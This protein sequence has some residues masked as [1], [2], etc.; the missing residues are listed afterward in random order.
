MTDEP[1]IPSIAELE[2]QNGI[3]P[4]RYCGLTPQDMSRVIVA[5]HSGSRRPGERV[6]YDPIASR[7]T[8]MGW[9]RDECGPDAD[10]E[11][12]LLL[13]QFFS[14]RID[15]LLRLDWMLPDAEFDRAVSE[16]LRMH[17]PELT[18]DARNVIAGNF[19]YSHK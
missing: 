11:R 14:A 6:G 17:F 3:P 18:E 12:L 8:R 19:S 2:R 5:Y 9:L 10:V 16:G 15:G 1:P 7:E 4:D 13:E